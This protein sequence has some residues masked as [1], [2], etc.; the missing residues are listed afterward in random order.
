MHDITVAHALVKILRNKLRIV[1]SD[2]GALTLKT[3]IL[4]NL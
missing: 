4:S 2:F 3:E 1:I